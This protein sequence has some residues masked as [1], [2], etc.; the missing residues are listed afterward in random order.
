MTE[1]AHEA[2]QA[3]DSAPHLDRRERPLGLGHGGRGQIPSRCGGKK[4]CEELG[5]GPD[6]MPSAIRLGCLQ[7]ALRYLKV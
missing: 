2:G 5:A 3:A 7:P 6:S 4:A 1:V